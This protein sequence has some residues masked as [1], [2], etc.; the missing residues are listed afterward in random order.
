MD[1][2]R[3]IA[4]AGGRE[5]ARLVIKNARVV[6]VFSGEIYRTDVAIDQG[7][8]AGLGAYHGHKILDLKGK[9]LCPGFID[10]HVHIESSMVSVPEFARTVVPRGTTTVII[11]PHAVSYTHL[12]LPTN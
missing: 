7:R 5:K 3:L 12:T 1:I 8:I 4:V 11:D 9:Y 6:N 10:G 2:E